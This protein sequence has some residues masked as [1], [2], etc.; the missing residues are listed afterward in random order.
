MIRELSP[1]ELTEALKGKTIRR[2]ND[3]SDGDCFCIHMDFEDG[4]SLEISNIMRMLPLNWRI[5]G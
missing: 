5:N 3:D 2:V 1:L 4:S